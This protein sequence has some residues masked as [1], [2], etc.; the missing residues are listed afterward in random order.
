MARGDVSASALCDAT[1]DRTSRRRRRRPPSPPPKKQPTLT[2][3]PP[4]APAQPRR[5]IPPE[6]WEQRLAGVRVD[7]AALNRLVANW[8]VAE[9]HVTAA[10]A[11]RDES[12]TD[13]GA[14]LAAVEDRVRVRRDVRRGDVE[15][16][17]GRV[18]ELD[19]ELLAR[20]PPLLFRLH[21]QQLVELVRR[22]DSAGALAFAEEYLAPAGEEHP[23]LLEELGESSVVSPAGVGF[24]PG[25]KKK[26][27]LACAFR[28][29]L[30][31]PDPPT[32]PPHRQQQQQQQ[33]VTE[34]AMALLAFD[35]PASCPLAELLSPRQRDRAAAALNAAVLAATGQE[36]EARLPGLLRLVVWAQRQ[37]GERA[38]F[39]RMVD[40]ATARLSSDPPPAAAAAHAGGGGA[41]P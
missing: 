5:L 38:E 22:G 28:P 41:A 6:Q 9:G 8:L 12:G 26:R 29:P 36:R 35:D 20:R 24:D 32:L 34:R 23:E 16:A 7:R 2:R 15:G 33:P 37:L 1:R 4:G 18:N 39:P 13:P 27:A 25:K 10:A 19:P 11:F 17:V 40:L 31:K 3:Q 14:D 30:S 21:C